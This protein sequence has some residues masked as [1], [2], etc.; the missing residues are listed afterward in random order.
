MEI[1]KV[2]SFTELG[3][4]KKNDFNKLKKWKED[5]YKKIRSN[6]PLRLKGQKINQKDLRFDF[7][8]LAKQNRHLSKLYKL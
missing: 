2:I 7:F 8:G 1:S 5:D 3:E 4:V 6:V